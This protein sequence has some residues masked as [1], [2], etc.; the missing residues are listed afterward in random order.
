MPLFGQDRPVAGAVQLGEVLGDFVTGGP[1]RRADEAY[2]KRLKQNFDAFKAYEDARISR[3][4][5]NAREG[6]TADLVQRALAGDEAALGELGAVSMGMATGQPNFGTFTRGAKDVA[7]M[8]LDRQIEE[9]LNNGDAAK[10]SR[11]SAV[12]NDKVLPELGA[13]GKVVF[14]PV[15]GSATMTALGDAD[16]AATRALEQQRQAGA[17]ASAATAALRNVQAAAGG[18]NPYSGRSRNP[19]KEAD[20]QVKAIARDAFYDARAAGDDMK[21][22]T[23]GDIEHALR[24]G[25][26]W[27]SPG[28]V[29]YRNTIG[30]P[31]F[32]NVVSGGELGADAAPPRDSLA[33]IPKAAIDHLRANP[34]LRSLFDDKYGAGAAA[35]VLGQ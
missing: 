31:D 18:W 13:G 3:A 8:E 17:G 23:Q 26:E 5:A 11:L 16:V 35:S 29:K 15:D 34:N 10:A 12:K 9:A 4:Q 1:G 33:G 14:T 27:V 24:S 19:S 7:E 22:I 30:L 20:A 32:S 6:M 2:P 21:G 28:G 25:R